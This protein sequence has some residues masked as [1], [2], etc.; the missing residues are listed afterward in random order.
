MAGAH[1]SGTLAYE[2]TF[3]AGRT[4]IISYNARTSTF[5]L[6]PT[7]SSWAGRSFFKIFH[8][9]GRQIPAVGGGSSTFNL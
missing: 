7:S 5:S 1:Q 4:D 6:L 3:C 8:L 2:P 9:L